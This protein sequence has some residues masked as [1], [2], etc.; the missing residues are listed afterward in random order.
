MLRKGVT[1]PW[2]TADADGS[3]KRVVHSFGVEGSVNA[4]AEVEYGWKLFFEI[5]RKKVY[6]LSWQRTNLHFVPF[7][8]LVLAPVIVRLG[9]WHRFT[10]R[11][12]QVRCTTKRFQI[13]EE[14]VILTRITQKQKNNGIYLDM[15]TAEMSPNRALQYS[16]N[17]NRHRVNPSRSV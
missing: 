12:Q 8:P 5:R 9:S 3:I 7:F 15:V 4:I 17:G 14:K 11:I 13:Y 10:G 16:R 2:Y 6:I 1:A